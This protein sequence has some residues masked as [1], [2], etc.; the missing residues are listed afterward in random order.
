MIY[1]IN[2]LIAKRK[3][4]FIIPISMKLEIGY[5]GI[6]EIGISNLITASKN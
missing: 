2:P 1:R 3:S 6:D 4:G 5:Q